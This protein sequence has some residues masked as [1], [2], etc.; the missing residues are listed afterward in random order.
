LERISTVVDSNNR[1]IKSYWFE[2]L[3]RPDSIGTPQNDIT[4]VILNPAK[5]DEES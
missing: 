2:I 5:R 4:L 1:F 3:R